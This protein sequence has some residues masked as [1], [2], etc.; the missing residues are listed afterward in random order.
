MSI[1][2]VEQIH[3]RLR[4]ELSA[5]GISLAEAARQAGEKDPQGL[6]DVVGGR[7]RLSAEL[8]A[9]LAVTGIDTQYVLTG[10]R[11]GTAEPQAR[12]ALTPRKQKLLDLIEMLDEKGQEEIQD[13]LE[14]IKR[15]RDMERELAELKKRTRGGQN[16]L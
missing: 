10:V 1:G 12:F 15:M 6:K 3:L 7:K 11:T 4:E 13:E 2:D 16:K 9:K 8:L 14:K 5:R